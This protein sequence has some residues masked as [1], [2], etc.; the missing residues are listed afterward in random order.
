MG[1]D[2][3][4]AGAG[5]P[6]GRPRVAVVGHVEWT[7][8][9]GLDEVPAAGEVIHADRLWQGPAG[10]GAVAAV[11]L[12]ELAGGCTFFTALGDDHAGHRSRAELEDRGVRVLAA[13]RPGPTRTAVSLVD[14]QGERTTVTLGE[15]LQP[16]AA[17]PFDWAELASFDAVF[18]TAGD[19]A[20]LH[21]ARRAGTLVVTAREFATVLESGVRV[22]ALVGSGCDPAE[23]CNPAL[24]RR[25]PGLVVSTR[26]RHGGVFTAC[27]D[28]P[29]RY[30]PAR[31]PG[32]LV[33]TYGV[34]DNF[35]AVLTY[36]LAAGSTTAEALDL[37]AQHGAAC[38][39]RR[40]PFPGRPAPVR[41]A[42]RV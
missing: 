24:L 21:A 22:D 38:T 28:A 31:A 8:I 6:S 27:G 41:R 11:R 19:A 32:P 17:D 18:F 30:R 39:A 13:P 10:G 23:H 20:L 14:R 2:T 34:G 25:P 36:A 16:A 9:A 40:G 42:A 3:R 5:A 1:D 33:D 4:L 15:R 26:G 29:R 35:A 37:A 12:A 7:T